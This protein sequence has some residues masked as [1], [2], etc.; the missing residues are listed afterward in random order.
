MRGGC[1]LLS[2]PP[3]RKQIVIFNLLSYCN[4]YCNLLFWPPAHHSEMMLPLT[5]IP[6]LEAYIIIRDFGWVPDMSQGWV[7]CPSCT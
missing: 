1:P 5:P 6:P 7:T 2:T 3:K 4:L